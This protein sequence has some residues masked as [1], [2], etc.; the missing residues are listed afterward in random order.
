MIEDVP[1]VGKTTLIGIV[2]SL[3]NKTSGRVS[4]FGYDIDPRCVEIA[5]KGVY[6]LKT[7]SQIPPI[8]LRHFWV[9]SGNLEGK[10]Q[11]EP[12]IRAKCGFKVGSL[13]DADAHPRDLFDIVFC[14][15][16][17][18]Y[19]DEKTKGDVL[20][21][22]AA[23]MKPPGYL[24]LGGAESTFGLTQ[25]LVSNAEQRGLFKLAV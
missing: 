11:I 21:R 3:V 4:V 15:N 19:F 25:K 14:R 10:V 24:F 22:I 8:H 17:L 6:A 16:V 13:L 5:K 18:I 7:M 23:Q 9:G 1:G 2:T 20:D 12:D